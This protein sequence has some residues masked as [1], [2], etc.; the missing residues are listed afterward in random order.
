M[1]EITYS[2]KAHHFIEMPGLASGS[3]G[4]VTVDAKYA[5]IQVHPTYSLAIAPPAGSAHPAFEEIVFYANC[6]AYEHDLPVFIWP[7]KAQ[8]LVRPVEK[9]PSDYMSRSYY[10]SVG[11]ACEAINAIRLGPLGY[12]YFRWPGFLADVDIPYSHRYSGVARELSLYGQALRQLDPLSEFL[13]YYRVIESAAGN[14][15]KRWIGSNLQRLK[16][17]DF[18][19]LHFGSD[20]IEAKQKRRTNLFS[21][22][23]RRA[24]A[25]L[26]KL[27]GILGGRDIADYLYHECRCGIAHG[28]TGIKEYDFSYTIEEISSDLYVPKL[29]SRIVIEDNSCHEELCRRT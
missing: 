6:V 29:L 17:F 25:R 11:V 7:V 16:N 12:V 22:Y 21:V 27:H 19:F 2:R 5:V 23:R 24:L 13:C 15:G 14:S 4:S 1:E 3:V 26:R 28:R 8:A 10:E 18:G 9:G 20:E